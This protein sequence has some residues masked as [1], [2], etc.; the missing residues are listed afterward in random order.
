MIFFIFLISILSQLGLLKPQ[1]TFPDKTFITSKTAMTTIVA[2]K[3]I[4]AAGC[5]SKY[6]ESKPSNIDNALRFF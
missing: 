4:I 1:T 6:P 3:A 5:P 2:T